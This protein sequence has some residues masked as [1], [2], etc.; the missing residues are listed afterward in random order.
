MKNPTRL[1]VVAKGDREI[2][3]TRDFD[4]PRTLVF[5]AMTKPELV[6][7]WLGVFGGWTLPVCE[8]DL[9]VGGSYRYQWHG[10][11][12]ERMGM[13]GVYREI[14]RPDRIVSTEQFD[15]SWYP[16]GA[17]GT[18]V[19]AERGGRTTVTTTVRYDSREA[20]DAVMK[21]PMETGLAAGYQ[22]LDSVLASAAPEGV[23]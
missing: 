1:Q 16:G 22:A 11:N 2:V 20:R 18:A 23:R 6:R 15:E 21:S 12:G 4:A 7:R 8:I 19:F 5:D 10:P 9:R 3:I 14:I 13:R 17:V